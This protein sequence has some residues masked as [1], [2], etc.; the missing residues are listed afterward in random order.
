[1]GNPLYASSRLPVMRPRSTLNL[2]AEVR[3]LDDSIDYMEHVE[4]TFWGCDGAHRD[5]AMNTCSRCHALRCLVATRDA[6]K[7][8]RNAKP[9]NLQAPQVSS[10]K[11]PRVHAPTVAIFAVLAAWFAVVLWFGIPAIRR[12]LPETHHHESK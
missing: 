3:R 12:A 4:C 7:S 9:Q 8:S 5:V 10:M 6:G 1:M 11:L 2:R